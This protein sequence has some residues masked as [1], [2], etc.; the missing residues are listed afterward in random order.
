MEYGLSWDYFK[1]D[2]IV[3]SLCRYIPN[4][5]SAEYEEKHL[6]L[7]IIKILITKEGRK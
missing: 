7:L 2:R 5:L 4:K 1:R 6:G 3:Q